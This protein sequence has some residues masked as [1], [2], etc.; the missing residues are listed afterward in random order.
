MIELIII[1]AV[2]MTL[3]IISLSFIVIFFKVSLAIAGC[4]IR[5]IM[6]LIIFPVILIGVLMLIA[7]NFI[8]LSFI[9]GAIVLIVIFAKIFKAALKWATKNSNQ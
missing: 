9:V 1:L 6:G 7:S 8:G 3:A 5:L 4:L 2:A